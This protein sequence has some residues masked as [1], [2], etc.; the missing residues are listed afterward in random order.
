LFKADYIAAHGAE[1]FA[2]MIEAEGG[3]VPE[4]TS[5][6]LVLLGIAGLIYKTNCHSRLRPKKR[7]GSGLNL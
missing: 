2:S 3:Y 6:I 4:P 7:H 5:L 1:G